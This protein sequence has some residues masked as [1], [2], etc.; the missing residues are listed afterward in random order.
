MFGT[1]LKMILAK[2]MAS[3][4]Q[5]VV[6]DVKETDP[7]LEA[8]FAAVQKQFKSLEDNMGWYCK[9]NP[10]SPLCKKRQPI[11]YRQKNK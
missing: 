6:Q 4:M 10:N 1:I 7:N 2:R 3:E 11:V 9:A 8:S 5:K